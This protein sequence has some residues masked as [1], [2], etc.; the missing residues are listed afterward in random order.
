MDLL[1]T[2]A[3]WRGGA[4]IAA[5][6]TVAVAGRSGVATKLDIQV[7]IVSLA[8][9]LCPVVGGGVECVVAAC[10]VAYLELAISEGG[11]KIRSLQSWP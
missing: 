1:A 4:A 6:A 10:A 5:V 11:M 9:H 8:L 3:G 2:T 7:D